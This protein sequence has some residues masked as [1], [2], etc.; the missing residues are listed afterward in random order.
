MEVLLEGGLAAR[1]LGLPH[2]LHYRGNTLDRPKLV[3]DALDRAS[4]P[5][6]PITSTASRARPRAFSARGAAAKVEV[7]YNPVDVGRFAP[8]R[9]TADVRAALGAT[10]G[11]SLIGTVGRIHPRKDLETF[12]RGRRVSRARNCAPSSIV[13]AP[14]RRVE[15]DY[16]AAEAALVSE[17]GLAGG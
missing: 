16:G 3:F 4:G 10:N 12:L 5:R 6:R 13:G 2:V 1:L 9:R 17:L 11:D 14:R 15:R 8:P 7:L